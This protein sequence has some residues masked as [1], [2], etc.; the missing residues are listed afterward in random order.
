M[1]Q[2]FL[3]YAGAKLRN[4]LHRSPCNR[5]PLMTPNQLWLRA[6]SHKDFSTTNSSDFTP[7]F[8][9][10]EVPAPTICY[11][12]PIHPCNEHKVGGS[13][14]VGL[15][16]QALKTFAIYPSNRAQVS[17]QSVTNFFFERLIGLFIQGF[18]TY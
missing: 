15:G 11:T 7:D 17:R 9:E 4:R 16:H 8:N 12:L 14:P 13:Q 2:F 10:F 1:P 3:C 5:D 6:S 18:P